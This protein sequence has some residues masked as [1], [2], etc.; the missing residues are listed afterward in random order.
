MDEGFYPHI[1]RQLFSRLCL[2]FINGDHCRLRSTRIQR[3][4]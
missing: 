1:V 2:L 4:Q 3:F